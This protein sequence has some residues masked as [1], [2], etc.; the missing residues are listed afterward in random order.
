MKLSIVSKLPTYLP[1]FLQNK[2]KKK[3]QKKEKKRK[4][5][6]IRANTLVAKK[7]R[8]FKRSRKNFVKLL[9]LQKKVHI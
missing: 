6:K 7:K 9:T 8:N 3:K 1:I 2:K 4:E 5:K